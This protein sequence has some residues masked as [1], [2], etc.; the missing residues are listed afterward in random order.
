M[1]QLLLLTFVA[2]IVTACS[3]PMREHTL[4]HMRMAH[5]EDLCNEYVHHDH[6]DQHGGSYWHTHCI[7]NHK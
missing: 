3:N 4:A 5:I 2:A 7:D 6:D 1:K